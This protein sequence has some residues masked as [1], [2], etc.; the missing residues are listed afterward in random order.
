MT[1][2][3]SSQTDEKQLE[4]IPVKVK[5]DSTGLPLL[6]QPSTS[7]FDPLN[8]PNWLKYTILGEIC[9][10]A[11]LGT[12]NVAVINPAVVPLSTEFGIADVTGTYQT[13]IAIG[14]GA[15][16]PVFFTPFANVYG[17]RPVYLLSVLIG[18]A[19][20]LGSARSKSYGTLMFAR[21]MNGFGPSAAFGLGAGTVVDVF[22]MHERGK[23]MGLFTLMY[24]NG[25]HVAPIV[26]GYIARD[27]GWRW[28]FYVSAILNGA[29]FMICFFFMPETLFDRPEGQVQTTPGPQSEFYEGETQPP[30][31]GEPFKSPPMS[32]KTYLN[33]MQIPDPQRPPSRRLKMNQFIIKPFSMLKYPSVI[34]P[35]LF[36]A[37]NYGLA[38]IEPALTLAPLFT[39][40]YQ[41]DTVRNGLANGV[42]LLVGGSLGELC[43][44]PITD[45]MMQRARRRALS[46]GKPASAEIRLQGIWTGAFAVPAGLLIHTNT[47]LEINYGQMASRCD[48]PGHLLHR[49]LAWQSLVLAP[50]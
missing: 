2:D 30:S 21:A 25:S 38:S 15:L 3:N 46:H 37:V 26:G 7:P 39:E 4:H 14:A 9:M 28:C 1:L 32:L 10:L 12:L 43:S 6:P 44:S 45:K 24:T 31:A 40:L 18:F 47:L 33:R 20:A 11:F 19:S 8:Y 42:S 48:L 36:F 41:F 35:A 16:G 22:F 23:A 5:V 17:R 34:F 13:T 50:R 29:M 49:V 27:L